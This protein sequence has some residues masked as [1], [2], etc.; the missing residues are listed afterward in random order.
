MGKNIAAI[1]E[2]RYRKKGLFFRKQSHEL[3]R[4]RRPAE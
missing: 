2:K 4:K 3:P 1:R